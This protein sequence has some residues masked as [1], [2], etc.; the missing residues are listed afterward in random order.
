MVDMEKA[1]KEDQSIFRD[2]LD[3]GRKKREVQVTVFKMAPLPAAIL[4]SW[5]SNL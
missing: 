3:L 2:H 1:I 5:Y 4:S